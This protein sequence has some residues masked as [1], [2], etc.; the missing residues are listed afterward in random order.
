MSEYRVAPTQNGQPAL[1]DTVTQDCGSM[2][3]FENTL[4]WSFAERKDHA[5][6]CNQLYLDDWWSSDFPAPISKADSLGAHVEYD[7][8]ST[9]TFW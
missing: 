6:F 2:D 4:A 8:N 3:L 5:H 1:A 9:T 7:N